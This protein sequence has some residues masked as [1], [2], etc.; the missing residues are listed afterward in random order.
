[1]RRNLRSSWLALSVIA[2]CGP[3]AKPDG[4]PSGGGPVG[5]G[6][7]V[8]GNG[9][10]DDSDAMVDE[11]CGCTLGTTQA[12]W[13]GE[14]GN[15][16]VGACHDGVQTCV[17]TDEFTEWSNCD[18]SAM[19]TPDEFG[20]GVDQD[21]S[22]A[23]GDSTCS[24]TELG[25]NDLED[26]DCDGAIDCA[27]IDCAMDPAC[28]CATHCVPSSQ[29]WCDTPTDCT[30]GTQVCNPD[31][32]WGTCTE[33]A[34]PEACRDFGETTFGIPSFYDTECCLSLP[35]ACCQ[36]YPMQDSVGECAGIT[37]CP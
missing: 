16:G 19:P 29:R 7:E 22:G 15:R 31:G 27:D 37:T 14:V 9:L 33:T 25:C 5:S 28:A 10:D 32:T 23:D 20:D 2:A 36:N 24:I 21:C 17:G 34:T 12:C 4:D 30:W 1:M 26:G 13:P 11:E 35:N 3:N 18:G 6:A 8:C